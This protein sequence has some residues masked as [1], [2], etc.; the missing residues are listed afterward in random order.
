MGPLEN[1]IGRPAAL[2]TVLT[3]LAGL[4]A[5]SAT[6]LGGRPASAANPT[7]AHPLAY[8]YDGTT[9]FTIDVIDTVTQASVKRIPFADL[10]GAIA[11]TPDA[12]YVL[13]GA[14]AAG[15][16]GA[17]HPPGLLATGG[18]V[19]LLSTATN[20]FVNVTA[21]VGTDPVAI[22]VTPDGSTAY[23]V[24]TIAAQ[25]GEI[26]P[27]AIGPGPALTEE[28][29]LLLPANAVPT[30]DA[31][32]PD[33]KLLLVLTGFGT[34]YAYSLPGLTP[35]GSVSFP[36]NDSGGNGSLVVAPDGSA[37]YV[38]SSS[39]SATTAVQPIALP[40]LVSGSAIPLTGSSPEA[41]RLALAV[42]PSGQQT[43]YLNDNFPDLNAVALAGPSASQL[44]LSF[45]AADLAPTPDGS[46][47]QLTSIP[48]AVP[49]V[50]ADHPPGTVGPCLAAGTCQVGNGRIAITPD[51]APVAAF[52]AT[53]GIP[54][55]PTS[56]DASSS[57][58]AYGSITAYR[59][60]FGDG[61][62]QQTSVPTT[63]HTYTKAGPVTVVLTETDAA[64]TSVSRAP[65]STV[66]TGRTMSRLG[67]PSAQVSHKVTIS[68]TP[69][70]PSAPTTTASP[71]PSPG[72][73]PRITL[74]PAVGPPGSVVA[75]DGSGFPA[76]TAVVLAWSPG[77][78]RTPVT[79]DAHGAFTG[80]RVLVFPK[81]QL[82][83]RTLT[84]DPFPTATAG[85]LVVP[86]P[87]APGGDG[88][89]LPLQLLFR[90]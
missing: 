54:G 49:I 75:V 45:T 59:W 46:V 83:P 2:G 5:L 14:T 57:T 88:Q 81:D 77:I 76:N 64:G 4:F 3:V 43:L 82:G 89:D 1:R 8:T 11:I 34:L 26:V 36:I 47:V 40:G 13:I 10:P 44:P 62:T 60:D 27:V 23:V 18:Y 32:T 70:S 56:F 20:A 25:T 66:F 9:S 42:T 51:Q 63:S 74:S 17:F 41:T 22:A 19:T 85:F 50:G 86:P 21:T 38:I 79:T 58:V 48:D 61:T 16:V 69:A 30:D 15:A 78:G 53:P 68:T 55:T 35:A 65:P 80:R 29:E 90:G 39:Q 71:L 72:F 67:G 87:L 33:G 37:A 28:Q 52:S 84:A 6:T 73:S 12:R 24:S 7:G 31:V